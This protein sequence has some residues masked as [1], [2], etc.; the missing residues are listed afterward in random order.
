M[1][2]NKCEKKLSRVACPDVWKNGARNVVDGKDGGR[3][4][5]GNM[6]LVK[7]TNQK[8]YFNPFGSKCK[9]CKA[10]V[11]KDHTYCNKCSYEK[12]MCKMCGIK[13]VSTKFY[14]MSNH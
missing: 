12:G 6:I 4:V 13:M 2:C 11:E 9:T 14:K 8:Q 5:G 1:V 10:K 7:K 3:K